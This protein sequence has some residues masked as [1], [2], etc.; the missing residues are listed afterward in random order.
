MDGGLD[1]VEVE[2]DVGGRVD[3]LVVGSSS[4]SGSVVRDAVLELR[5]GANDLVGVVRV[6]L[7][8]DGDVVSVGTLD[9]GITLSSGSV[10]AVVVPGGGPLVTVDAE[11]VIPAMPNVAAGVEDVDVGG[12]RVPAGFIRSSISS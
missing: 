6:V 1:E 4:S 10:V 11:G 7:A 2:V 12:T 9:S 8:R 5:L 3:V